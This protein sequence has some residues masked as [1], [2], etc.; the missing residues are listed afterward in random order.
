MS[1][2]GGIIGVV[3]PGIVL[4]AW[5]VGGTASVVGEL[6]LHGPPYAESALQWATPDPREQR[7]PSAGLVE[8]TAARLQQ[9]KHGS[10]WGP[11]DY[12][13]A[14]VPS[15]R[16]HIVSVNPIDKYTWGAAAY[17]V[18]AGRCYLI[19]VAEDPRNPEYGATYY[20]RLPARESCVGS[21][22]TR[23]SVTSTTELPE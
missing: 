20:G 2:P 18:R 13:P 1:K 5:G 21:A 9:L 15:T 23:A 11:I 7:D 10:G 16:P 3:L 8:F 14:D 22:A 12:V 4:L 17:S 6:Y 19:L